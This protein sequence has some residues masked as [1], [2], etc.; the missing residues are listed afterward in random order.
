MTKPGMEDWLSD[1]EAFV[2]AYSGH[3]HEAKSKAEH[4]VEIARQASQRDRAAL[5]ETGLAL[6]EALFGYKTAGK[7]AMEAL[8]LSRSRDVEYG[9]AFALALSGQ[10]LP[11]QLNSGQL[12]ESRRLADDL[13]K[14]FPED[15]AV[16][17]SYL[18]VLRALPALKTAPA[19]AIAILQDAGPYELGTPPSSVLGFF[20]NLYPVYVRGLAFLSAGQGTEAVAEFRKIISHR[21]IAVSDPIGALAHLQLG[22]AL[23]LARDTTGAKTAYRDFFKLWET[24]DNDIPILKDARAQYNGLQ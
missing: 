22:R 12:M 9:A 3:F 23:V 11:G 4:A 2:L 20:G 1:Q 8:A 18:P 5:W 15:T 10:S 14:R 6:W 24:A 17:T 16:K 21:N 7:T 13:V 19:K